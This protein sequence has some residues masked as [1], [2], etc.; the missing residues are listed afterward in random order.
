MAV[1]VP[2]ERLAL[3]AEELGRYAG[4]VRFI[5]MTQAGRNPGRIIPG[6][7]RAFADAQPP[8]RVRIIGEP[9]WPGRTAT[10]CPACAQHEALINAAFHGRPVPALCPHDAARLEATV[11][12]DALATHPHV[13]DGGRQRASAAYSPDDVVTRCNQPM[14]PPSGAATAHFS[15]PELPAVRHFA[16][17]RARELGLGGGR[18][19]DVALAVAEL[20]TN[21]VVHGGGSGTLRVWGQQRQVVCEV[22]DRGRLVDLRWP[23]G[24]PRGGRGRARVA[25]GE[26]ARRPGAAAHRSVCPAARPA[27]WG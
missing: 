11:L 22:R 9:I 7:L 24:A 21:S 13:I 15:A 18:L 3:L 25:A 14:E 6:V 27:R 17:Q 12:A 8:G 19:E 5:D 16:V 26:S 20:T 23:G 2:A 1:A 10:E 4:A